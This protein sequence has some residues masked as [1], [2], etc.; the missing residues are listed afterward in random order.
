[1]EKVDR[2]KLRWKPLDEYCFAA[3]IDV[4]FAENGLKNIAIVMG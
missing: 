3:H 4:E 1:M 2:S